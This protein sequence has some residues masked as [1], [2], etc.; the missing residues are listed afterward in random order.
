MENTARS[1]ADLDFDFALEVH[2]QL[3]PRRGV[4]IIV[5]VP[6]GFA[7]HDALCLHQL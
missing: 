4:K 6:G 1:V 7:E 3:P 2:D 5:V